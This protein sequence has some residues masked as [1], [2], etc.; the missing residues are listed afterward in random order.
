MWDRTEGHTEC[1]KGVTNRGGKQL[2]HGPYV[3][4]AWPMKTVQH[5]KHKNHIYNIGITSLKLS[6]TYK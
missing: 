4:K 1:A 6:N 5:V 3:V 2:A